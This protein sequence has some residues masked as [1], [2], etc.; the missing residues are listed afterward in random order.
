MNPVSTSGNS[1]VDK[2]VRGLIRKYSSDSD[3]SIS[4]P[5]LK[6]P[7]KKKKPHGIMEGIAHSGSAAGTSTTPTAVPPI[8][9]HDFESLSVI[10]NEMRGEMHQYQLNNAASIKQLTDQVSSFRESI[11]TR[12][13]NLEQSMTEKIT[14]ECDKVKTDVM[15]EVAAANSKIDALTLSNTKFQ[16]DVQAF[17]DR[18][19]LAEDA[20]T[21]AGALIP[22]F[23]PENTVIVSGV[24]YV[25]TEDPKVEAQKLIDAISNACVPPLTQIQV[26]NA[27]RTVSRNNKPGL[28]KIQLPSRLDKINIL[29]NKRKLANDTAYARAFVR[30]SQ[31]HTDRL[32]HLNFTTLLNEMGL[33]DRYRIAANGRLIEKTDD[34]NQNGPQNYYQRPPPGHP[35]G[36]PPGPPPGHYWVPTGPAHGFPPLQRQSNNYN[37]RQQPG[38]H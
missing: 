12:I 18:V 13:N 7:E 2:S 17:E 22:D 34:S 14:T 19:K 1:S 25:N 27:E 5:A 15:L 6:P 37:Q 24:R 9:V 35:H 28:L 11:T 30:G 20:L 33:A 10:L 32:I 38:R 3:V 36:P 29:K 16:S 21:A 31:S 23:H 26:V 4:P 8:S